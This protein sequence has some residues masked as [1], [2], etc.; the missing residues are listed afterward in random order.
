MHL[1][2]FINT[3]SGSPATDYI[4]S[5]GP[6]PADSRREGDRCLV[7]YEPTPQHILKIKDIPAAE[8]GTGISLHIDSVT[9]HAHSRNVKVLQGFL[10]FW[11]MKYIWLPLHSVQIPDHL[12]LRKE[13][14]E[15]FIHEINKLRNQDL[16][17]THPLADKIRKAGKGFPAILLMPGPSLSNITGKLKA[18]AEKAIIICISRT[19]GFALQ[20][21]V[22]PDLVIQLDC[23]CLQQRLF[24]EQ[25]FQDTTLL[26][27]SLAPISGFAKNFRQVFFTDSFDLEVLPNS[28]RPKESWLSTFLL[29]LGAAETLELESLYVFG[30]DLSYQ[31]KDACYY[32]TTD[33]A[34]DNATHV[35]QEFI[36]AIRNGEFITCDINN[37]PV[38]TTLQYFAT[39]FEAEM[40]AQEIM[41][42]AG[43]HFYNASSSGILSP[44]MFIPVNEDHI[45][46]RQDFNR[47]RF[48]KRLDAMANHRETINYNLLKHKIRLRIQQLRE[49]LKVAR[50]VDPSSHPEERYPL[51]QIVHELTLD[52]P[53]VMSS[54]GKAQF[55][56][57]LLDVWLTEARRALNIVTLHQLAPEA[58]VTLLCCPEEF[59]VCGE[60]ILKQHPN[61]QIAPLAVTD[62]FSPPATMPSVPFHRLHAD[63]VEGK[64][65]VLITRALLDRYGYLIQAM[66]SDN[67]LEYPAK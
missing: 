46:Q 63:A 51:F 34:I 59:E 14:K 31:N 55:T 2:T 19:V 57:G 11:F 56:C 21:G 40:F 50:E 8:L 39:A 32:N 7:I 61:W 48:R 1:R 66:P 20:E 33:G 26:S 16:L 4:I 9:Y 29:C 18:L 67:I 42:S 25:H 12:G 38:S 5:I 27:L 60:P 28:Y 65:I 44:E 6:L 23:H 52:N 10:A 49:A 62:I 64:P 17:L 3:L 41:Q 36:T 24:P 53:G 47:E 37:T 13:S 45:L 15:D 54:Q 22:E 35:E 43:T 30:S 58:P